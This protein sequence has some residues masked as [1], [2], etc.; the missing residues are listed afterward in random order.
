[1]K[2]LAIL[3]M[4]VSLGMTPPGSTK[5]PTA[6]W[7]DQFKT[8]RNAVYLA[9]KAKA[10]SFFRFPIQSEGNLIWY[11]VYD[12]NDKALEMMGGKSKPFTDKDFDKYFNKLFPKRFINTIMKIKSDVL[13]K[14]NA[15]ESIEFKEG[16][17]VTYKMYAT[18]DRDAK[19]VTLNLFSNTVYRDS[20]GKVTDNGEHSI[21]Y[22]FDITDQGGFVFKNV[23]I[24]G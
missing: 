9:D 2:I 6:T 7:V 16:K 19:T 18:V 20:K 13:D 12:G 21:I 22:V 23:S 8:F 17:D 24:A 1:M 14:K 15:T 11:V 3:S 10:K 5:S 4:I